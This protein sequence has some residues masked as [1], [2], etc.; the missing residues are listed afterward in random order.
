M[1]N[2][3]NKPTW[4]PPQSIA[5]GVG[6]SGANVRFAD[7]QGTGRA[8]YLAIDLSYGAV[9]A[10]LDGCSDIAAP[11]KENWVFIYSAYL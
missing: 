1:N 3:P 8:S 11:P 9:S 2:Y 7:L 4:L 6:T 5:G 10:W